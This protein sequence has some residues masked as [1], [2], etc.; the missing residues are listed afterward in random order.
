MTKHIL[1]IG[2]Q[3]FAEATMAILQSYEHIE[4]RHVTH[5]SIETFLA[6][7]RPDCAII[8]YDDFEYEPAAEIEALCRFRPRVTIVLVSSISIAQ[9]VISGVSI[10]LRPSEMYLILGPLLSSL[11][12]ESVTV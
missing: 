1:L 2:S 5:V 8:N 7:W 12:N 10:V 4:T 11:F 6:R 3:S 9:S